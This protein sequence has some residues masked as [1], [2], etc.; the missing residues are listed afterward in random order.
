MPDARTAR[1][2]DLD[3]L[4]ALFRV[5]EVSAFAEPRERA[6]R[7]WSDILLRDGAIVFVSEADGRVVATCMLITAPNLLRS[8]R[9]HG[10]LE[11]VMTHP[12]GRAMAAPS[13]APRSKR[14]GRGTAITFS[15]KAAAPIHGC[16]ASTKDAASSRGFAP[17]MSR[18]VPRVD[19]R[20]THA[21]PKP[22]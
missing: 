14:P 2:D 6:E 11:N 16:T 13:C 1:A 8:G 10:F 17:L 9:Q 3:A 22:A 4:L 5:S 19:V 20:R 21:A 15:C 7:I 12:A 18:I